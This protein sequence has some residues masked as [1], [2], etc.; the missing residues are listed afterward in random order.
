LSNTRKHDDLVETFSILDRMHQHLG[1]EQKAVDAYDV[2]LIEQL[3]EVSGCVGTAAV[4][5]RTSL[6]QVVAEFM[7]NQNEQEL[8]SLLD[9]LAV[10]AQTKGVDPI[11]YVAQFA[12]G[13]LGA[14]KGYA[15]RLRYLAGCGA[16]KPSEE[17]RR[18]LN[19]QLS[20]L[21]GDW[22]VFVIRVRNVT[23]QLILRQA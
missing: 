19:W 2:Q 11:A 6:D 9:E 1:I 10:E 8:N 17:S 18:I 5:V 20:E 23:S 4:I 22:K 15:K 3:L 12:E 21:I 16:L 7:A 13:E 14:V